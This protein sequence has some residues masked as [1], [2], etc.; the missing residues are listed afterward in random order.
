VQ[1]FLV[2]IQIPTI[3]Q[4]PYTPHP[5][6]CDFWVFLRL[7]IVLRGHCF[8]SV[9]E[10]QQNMRAVSQ[11]YKKRTSRGA[12]SNGKSAG[13]SV[14]VH[15]GS[16]SMVTGE[17]FIHIDFYYKLCLSSRNFVILPHTCNTSA[18]LLVIM[19]IISLMGREWYSFG[20]YNV[21]IIYNKLTQ[22]PLI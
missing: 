1:Q 18:H 7:K 22:S 14:F 4:P 19:M 15:E 8:V 3:I 11:L 21:I 20:K 13:A 5:T 17:G 2:R 12:S 9:Q 6:G 16:I 10:I